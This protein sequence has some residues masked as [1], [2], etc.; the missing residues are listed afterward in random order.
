METIT[1]YGVKFTTET[2]NG[3]KECH[4]MI[5]GSGWTTSREDA[6]SILLSKHGWRNNT[7]EL[8]AWIVVRTIEKGFSLQDAIKN[9]F[10]K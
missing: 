8:S 5:G 9:K 7:K 2:V 1:Q 6:E 3:I 4:Q 10:G